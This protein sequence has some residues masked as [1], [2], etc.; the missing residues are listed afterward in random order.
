MLLWLQCSE[1][2]VRLSNSSTYEHLELITHYCLLK[3]LYYVHF[4]RRKSRF[5]PHCYKTSW[6]KELRRKGFIWLT[7]PS[8]SHGCGAVEVV[9]TWSQSHPLTWA[10]S[11]C[12]LPSSAYLLPLFSQSG[13]Q[14]WSAWVCCPPHLISWSNCY[15]TGQHN[16]AHSSLRLPRWSYMVCSWKLK[17]TI[18]TR[19]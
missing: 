12:A 17:L 15:G 10:E 18:K 5:L 13:S 8:Y 2:M 11:T 6:Q 7:V 4:R 19:P 16:P 3:L 14:P 1:G 9:G